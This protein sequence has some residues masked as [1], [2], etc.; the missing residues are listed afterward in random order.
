MNE[1]WLAETMFQPEVKERLN[2]PAREA[3]G[4]TPPNNKKV[5][6]LVLKEHISSSIFWMPLLD[7][8]ECEVRRKGYTFQMY[9]VNETSMDFLE[10]ADGYIFV[11]NIPTYIYEETKGT[12]RPIVW[13]FN[14]SK[15]G[16]TDQVCVNNRYGTYMMAQ[17][18]IRMGHRH[19]GY[20]NNSLDKYVLDFEERYQ[21]VVLCAQDYADQGVRCELLS[22]G[23]Q[24]D[25]IDMLTRKDRPTFIQ[26]CH[27]SLALD[28]VRLARQ[29]ML[30]IP[31]DLSVAGFDNIQA[32]YISTPTLATVGTP[33]LDIAISAVELL[34]KRIKSPATAH[35]L[36]QVQPV[37]LLR[38]S[39]APLGSA[40][41]DEE[42]EEDERSK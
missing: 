1:G 25:L 4:F 35:E 8:L 33:F 23:G 37:L 13:V 20:L 39:L 36:I 28:L 6:M 7:M 38:D 22:I 32:T 15:N 29:L 42:T 10:G 31:E 2:I 34:D 24:E 17:E 40:P 5:N 3:H 16:N 14:N 9:V 12:D 27:D 18:A 26:V 21:G 30:R 11:G 19:L 41:S